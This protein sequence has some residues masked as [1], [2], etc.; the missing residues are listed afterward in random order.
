MIS[1]INSSN[2][3]KPQKLFAVE[4]VKSAILYNKEEES[5]RVEKVP[6]DYVDLSSGDNT[7][8]SVQESAENDESQLF[9][10]A[11]KPSKSHEFFTLLFSPGD[12]M[13]GHIKEKIQDYTVQT[14]SASADPSV[15]QRLDSTVDESVREHF[16][17]MS[18]YHYVSVEGL[19][20][21]QLI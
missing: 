6:E 19:H 7:D 20:I 14:T 12:E 15:P 5:R 1:K 9:H 11:Y 8:V 18:N 10:V 13:M 21:N 3:T 4:S 2:L 16:Y 17:E